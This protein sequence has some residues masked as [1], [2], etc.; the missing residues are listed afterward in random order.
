MLETKKYGLSI[1]HRLLIAF[2]SIFIIGCSALTITYYL[3][4]R[5]SISRYANEAVIR[6]LE[7]I[8]DTFRNTIQKTLIRE[9]RLLSA[10]P[11]LDEFL[12]S[13]ESTRDI[14][15]RALERLFLQE[16][17]YVKEIEK[18]RFVDSRGM[19]RVAVSKQG[20]IREYRS[21]R[22]EPFFLEIEA[23]PP[24]SITQTNLFPDS[25]DNKLFSI[26]IHKTDPDIGEF[27]G[28]IIV[29][30][31]LAEFFAF[32]KKIMI[33]EENPVW[34]FS[35]SGLV[36][37][38]PSNPLQLDPRPF[39]NHASSKN[40]TIYG[41]HGGLVATSD[42]AIINDSPLMQVCISIPE[43]LLY[44]DIQ[45]VLRFLAIVFAVSLF[46]LV[47]AVFFVSRYL[48][49]PLIMLANAVQK[50][51]KESFSK[52][53]DIHATGEVG[54]LV[55]SFNNMANDLR[56]TTVSKEYV[57]RIFQAMTNSLIV[58]DSEGFIESV[59]SAT[60]SLLGYETNELIGQP[61]SIITTGTFFTEIHKLATINKQ[62][63]SYFAKNGHEFPMLFSSSKMYTNQGQFQAFVCQAIDLSDK[64][65]A[66]Q[67]KKLLE[68]QLRQSHK[69]EAIGTLAGGIAHDFN[70]ILMGIIGYAELAELSNVQGKPAVEEIRGIIK[71]GMRARDLVQQILSFSRKDE[72]KVGPLIPSPIVK[73]ALKLLRS[74]IPSSIEIREEIDSEIGAVLADPMKI[75]QVVM[76]LCTNAVQAMETGKGTIT[77]ILRQLELNEEELL[78]EPDAQPGLY[79]E[80]SVNDTGKGID[81][82][83]QERIF[84]PFFTTKNVGSGTGMGLAVV[85]GIVKE[86]GGLIRITSNPETGTSFHVYI[87]VIDDEEGPPV[88]DTKTDLP[89]GSERILIVDDEMIVL[90][91][92]QKRLE[93]LGYE[94]TA[95]NNGLDAVRM[96][97]EK[98]N[99]FDLIITDQ[100]MPHMLGT[101]MVSKM[102]TIRPEIPVILCSGYSTSVS[103][104]TSK[105]LGIKLY[106]QKPVEFEVL[107]KSIRSVL[108][109]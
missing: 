68:V 87:P 104:E 84:D 30:Y 54:F 78:G 29:D 33:F 55:D 60:L 76:N 105:N 73:E 100:T 57:D 66:E 106:L 20:R 24:G 3:F 108:H 89:G 79:V 12:I 82:A 70:N 25:N 53:I 48:S 1:S 22:E 69:M 65:Q 91:I 95:C 83:I 6:E 2:L 109:S 28:A 46:L 31:N 36:L 21:L 9:L 85:H 37:T 35:P 94:V 96:L 47:I 90:E 77:I 80:L 41:L 75:H 74:T 39:T 11:L 62:E 107:S 50:L 19:E 63:T 45:Q 52:K 16:I 97:E 56:K 7:S 26:A 67:E 43:K 4:S 5:N 88:E 59:N 34:I 72:H 23:S 51:A 44:Q 92:M 71:G 14:N 42:L 17:K 8:N 58:L 15:A 61:F 102:L 40:I 86:Y 93:Y 10:N 18:I 32:A 103:E 49:S 13:S 38:K 64:K 98:P 27:G 101:E 99:A 81:P